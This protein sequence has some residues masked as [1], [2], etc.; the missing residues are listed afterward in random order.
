VQLLESEKINKK[1]KLFNESD[2]RMKINFP[3]KALVQVCYS[4][5]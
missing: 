1:N 4:D 2:I 5:K 3:D